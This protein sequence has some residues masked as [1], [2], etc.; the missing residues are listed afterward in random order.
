MPDKDTP[1]RQQTDKNGKTENPNQKQMEQ[2]HKSTVGYATF[3]D[4]TDNRRI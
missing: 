4:E 1:A 2:N 3:V